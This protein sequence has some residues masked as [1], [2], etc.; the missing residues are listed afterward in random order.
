[1]ILKWKCKSTK[2]T[3]AHGED[4]GRKNEFKMILE[5][6]FTADFGGRFVFFDLLA[7]IEHLNEKNVFKNVLG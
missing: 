2:K 1:M 6:E 3:I 4:G 5:Y 7:K